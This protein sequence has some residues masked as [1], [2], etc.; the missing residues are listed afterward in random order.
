[1]RCPPNVS[2]WV[3]QCGIEAIDMDV[4]DVR[5]VKAPPDVEPLRWV[6]YTSLPVQS[7]SGAWQVIEYYE[8]RPLVEEFHKG[9]KTGCRL[10][11]RQYRTAAR[12]EA[13]TALLCIVAVRLLQIRS[14]SRHQPERPAREIVPAKWI[15][16]L[17]H[18]RRRPPQRN[19]TVREFYREL[20]K[21]GGF[22][23][24][25]RDG[26]PGWITLWHGFY[27]LHLCLRGVEALERKCG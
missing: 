11:E 13:L 8:Q 1:M 19:W 23:G 20:A 5:E 16:L 21:L 10:E 9:I 18:L 17:Q 15:L 25:K 14:A 12:L 6:L 22:L 24:R 7:F 26:E 2:A 4:V 27:K 3:R